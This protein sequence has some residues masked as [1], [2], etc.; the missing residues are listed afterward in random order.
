M[1][2]LQVFNLVKQSRSKAMNHRNEII[3]Y[4]LCIILY[5]II[6]IKMII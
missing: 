2:H 5:I 4:Y 6:N 3:L 1:T